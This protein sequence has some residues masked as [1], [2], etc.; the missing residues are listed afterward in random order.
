MVGHQPYASA[1][2]TPGEI[3]GTHF[4]G[5]SWPQGTWFCRGKP[6][7]KF[8]V[9]PPGIDPRTLRLVVQCL[10]HYTTPVLWSR[11]G[12][13]NVEGKTKCG[14]MGNVV[15]II[16][17]IIII[18]IY[19]YII[20][21]RESTKNTVPYKLM[22]CHLHGGP[23]VCPV[24]TPQFMASKFQRLFSRHV[25]W[26]ES[27][28]G[29]TTEFGWCTNAERCLQVYSSRTDCTYCMRRSECSVWFVTY[30]G[31]FLMMRRSFDW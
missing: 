15:I 13:I 20:A 4:Q 14:L 19:I 23:G 10:H 22:C 2:F 8:P 21:I 12:K 3:P 28:N 18:Y 26:M 27:S 9:T 31:A 25:W 17:I 6:R 16:I 24:T 30:Q 1:A 7:K 29:F 5:L 11:M